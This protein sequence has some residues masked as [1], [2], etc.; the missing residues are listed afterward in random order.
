MK[1]IVRKGKGK[2]DRE[3]PLPI[4]TLNLLRKYWSE[5]KNPVWIF[6]APGRSNLELCP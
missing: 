1:L 2:K 6:P 5:H 3:I 4:H